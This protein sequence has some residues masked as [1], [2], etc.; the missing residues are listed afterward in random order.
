MN[1]N[2]GGFY[3]LL[4]DNSFHLYQK[5]TNFKFSTYIAGLYHRPNIADKFCSLCGLLPSWYVCICISVPG[6]AG[7]E[8][9]FFIAAH[10]WLC[11]GSMTKTVLITQG[12]FSYCWAVLTQHQVFCFFSLS[13][14]APPASRLGV[15]KK[16]RGDTT[17]AAD[18]DW[19]KGYFR[20]Q[21]HNPQQ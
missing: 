4:F 9:I 6:L 10:L 11:F 8:L 21:W 5:L 7:I 20:P 18:H 12:C 3:C 14:A 15:H 1:W 2:G 13:G 19:P 16:L 17:E